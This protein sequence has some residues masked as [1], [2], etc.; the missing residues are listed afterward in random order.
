MRLAN[1]LKQSA[2]AS[3][4]KALPVIY[5]LGFIFA[6]VRVLPAKEFGLL[7]L[8]QAVFLFIE[9][10][11]QALVQIPMA[12]FLSEGEHA[13]WAIPTSF[14]LSL[15]L[16]LLAGFASVLGAP[17]LAALMGDMDLAGL[18][19]YMPLMI[20]AFYLKNIASQICIAN[21]R[22]RSLF[23]IDATY[24]LG[25]LLLLIISYWLGILSNARLVI[26]INFYAALASSLLSGILTWQTLRATS[27]QLSLAHLGRF[28]A[29]GKYSLGAG[30]GNYFYSQID[31]FLIGHFYG[32]TK[33]AVYNAGKIIFRFYNIVSQATQ[34]VLLPLISRFDAAGQRE[35]LRALA[36]K[37][38][39]FLFL[40]LLPL[41]LLLLV[42]SEFLL[43]IVYHGKYNDATAILR[44]LVI[45]A[46]FLPWGAVG[47]NMQI[48]MGKPR[49]SFGFVLLVAGFNIIANLF[50]LPVFGVI[51]AA[52]A[53]TL[54]M[55]FGAILQMFYM[56]RTIQLRLQ[57]I[58]QRRLDALH[59][60]LSW[61]AKLRAASMPTQKI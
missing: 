1:Y 43:E 27:W 14:L 9:M 39:C 34:V 54:A 32:L 17:L 26:W 29:F 53:M 30:L 16:V 19:W 48:G 22:I 4:D 55:V 57:G 18:L 60:G 7:V 44:V 37:A 52:V 20:A 61:M 25:S 10:I 38:I 35:E 21:H 41:H 59:F 56:R 3:L 40:L 11:D 24:Y 2:W 6:V 8:F 23:V 45:G 46:F 33:V 5:G 58:W 47:S 51:G 36:E 15:I 13:A 49:V 42:G 31:T 50:L 28:L 12:K